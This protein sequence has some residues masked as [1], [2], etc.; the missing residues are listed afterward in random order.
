MVRETFGLTL[1][2]SATTTTMRVIAFTKNIR[3]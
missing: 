3:A 2:A 1:I